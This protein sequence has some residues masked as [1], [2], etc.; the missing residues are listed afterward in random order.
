MKH[1]TDIHTPDLPGLPSEPKKRGRPSTG[2]ALSPAERKRKQ[3]RKE[4]AAAWKDVDYVSKASVAQLVAELVVC[5]RD[6]FVELVEAINAELMKRAKVNQGTRS[7]STGP[8]VRFPKAKPVPAPVLSK[9]DPI[10]GRPVKYRHPEYPEA[11]WSGRG[12]RPAWVDEAR[13]KGY[14]W[15]ALEAK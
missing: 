13:R 12:R 5:V 3:R 4:R 7:F 2:K 1:P 8:T 6:G 15:E 9:P 11:T 10:T 14:S